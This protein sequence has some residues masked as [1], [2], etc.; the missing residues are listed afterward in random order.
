MPI[1]IG[2]IYA[3]I[4]FAAQILLFRKTQ[5]RL[6]HLLPLAVIALAYLIA[7]CLPIADTVMTGL[8]RNDGYNFYSFAALLTAGI[9][10]CGLIGDGIAWLLEK[11]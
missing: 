1:A 3:A 2:I 7:L 11:L 9:N 4:V 6:L 8:G 10:T 5:K